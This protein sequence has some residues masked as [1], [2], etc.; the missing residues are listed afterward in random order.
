[1]DAKKDSRMKAC[2]EYLK[3]NPALAWLIVSALVTA[4]F[5]KR[6]E[7]ELSHLPRPVAVALRLVAALGLDSAAVLQAVKRPTEPSDAPKA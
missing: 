1:M 4:V 5:R 6:T 7:E 2:I 3:E